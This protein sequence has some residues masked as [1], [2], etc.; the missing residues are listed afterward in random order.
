[1]ANTIVIPITELTRHTVT[2]ARGKEACRNLVSRLRSVR[3]RPVNVIVDFSSAPAV[4]GSFIDEMVIRTAEILADR[5]VRI[6]FRLSSESD[7][8]KLQKVCA[9]RGVRCK[10]QVGESGTLKH[11]R[12]ATVSPL[13]AQEYRGAL[14]TT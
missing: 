9:I 4:S 8:R 5:E 12:K 6:A 3:D 1:M 10:Y 14:F 7:T 13:E 11:T 2:R